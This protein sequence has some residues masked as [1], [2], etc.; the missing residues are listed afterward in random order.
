M[1]CEMDYKL[2]FLIFLL[3]NKPVRFAAI[4]CKLCEVK[5]VHPLSILHNS[6]QMYDTQSREM[7]ITDYTQL[8]PKLPTPP[9]VV[10]TGWLDQ[11]AMELVSP[12]G[13]L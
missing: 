10:A 13:S 2:Q 1:S 12:T 5:Q 6:A 11:L 8:L 4:S 9:T 7:H 3:G